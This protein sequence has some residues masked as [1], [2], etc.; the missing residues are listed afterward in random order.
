[1][2][3]FMD[4]TT[5]FY[6]LVN[7]LCACIYRIGEV[8]SNVRSYPFWLTWSW[9]IQGRVNELHFILIERSRVSAFVDCEE[10]RLSN[11]ENGKHLSDF[12]APVWVKPSAG[13]YVAYSHGLTS[14]M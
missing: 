12:D 6:S 7:G 11:L 8:I 2:P 14:L 10:V 9:G 1:M 13:A 4:L 3:E 5:S